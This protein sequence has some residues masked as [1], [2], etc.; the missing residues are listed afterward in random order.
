M[1]PLENAGSLDFF[2]QRPWRQGF[3]GESTKLQENKSN[4][5]DRVVS[6]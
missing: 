1:N 6:D 2:G 5:S 4:M 3:Q